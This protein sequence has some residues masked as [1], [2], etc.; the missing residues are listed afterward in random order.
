MATV[1]EGRGS[2]LT[3]QRLLLDTTDGNFEDVRYKK[4]RKERE[5]DLEKF[6]EKTKRPTFPEI[7][8]STV[9]V[10]VTDIF[11]EDTQ[12]IR[13]HVQSFCTYV[14]YPKKFTIKCV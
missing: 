9:L 10:R 1:A 3:V 5:M 12:L 14:L 13:A 11:Y 2:L 4:K 7:D 8:A 6:T